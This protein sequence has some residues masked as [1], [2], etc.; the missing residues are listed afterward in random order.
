M[1]RRPQPR[2][3][4]GFRPH[5]PGGLRGGGAAP[6]PPFPAEPVIGAGGVIPPAPDYFPR[7][8]E[9]CDQSQVLFIA[10]E[11]ITG[12]GRTGRWFALD[13]WGVQPDVVTFAKGATSAYLAPG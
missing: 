11:I 3:S 10:D 13:H 8:R 5:T 2:R 7:I 12:F 9:I 4:A 6:A 1:E